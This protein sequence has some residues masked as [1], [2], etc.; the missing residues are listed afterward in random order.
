MESGKDKPGGRTWLAIPW[1]LAFGIG[2]VLLF[3]NPAAAGAVFRL[4]SALAKFF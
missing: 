4:A 2:V 3:V 1:V